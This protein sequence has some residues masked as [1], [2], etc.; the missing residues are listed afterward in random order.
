MLTKVTI[1]A[2]CALLLVGEAC[3][4][5]E[6]TT[7]RSSSNTCDLVTSADIE[8]VQGEAVIETNTS[9]HTTAGIVSE[10]CF[11]RLRT[12]SKSISLEISRPAAGGTSQD[13]DDFWKR[14]FGTDRY[15]DDAEKDESSAEHDKERK[16][17]DRELEEEKR[18]RPQ[19]VAGLG[20][21]A[22]WSGSQINGSLFVRKGDVIV[23]LSIG[24]PE[25]QPTKIQK[26]SAL[27]AQALKNL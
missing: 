13:I 26:A 14:R 8:S 5:Q 23:R 20:D 22:F 24:G 4:S 7:T 11:Y 25:D 18:A 1:L 17:E 6:K 12:F 16:S 21:E 10:Q 27:A 19:A 9:N 15:Q 3:R 2:L